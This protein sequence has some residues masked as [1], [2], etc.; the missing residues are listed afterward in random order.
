MD[1]KSLHVYLLKDDD[2]LLRVLICSDVEQSRSVLHDPILHL[3]V[4]AY[5]CIHSLD[6]GHHGCHRQGLQHSVLIVLWRI[7]E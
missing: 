2:A 6:P 3:C 7:A 5:V 1:T 4:G